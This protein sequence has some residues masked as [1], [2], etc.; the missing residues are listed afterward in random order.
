MYSTVEVAKMC[1]NSVKTFRNYW[2]PRLI[3]AGIVPK[4]QCGAYWWTDEQVKQ[5]KELKGIE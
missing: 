1:H 4:K 5:I 2:L 3:K